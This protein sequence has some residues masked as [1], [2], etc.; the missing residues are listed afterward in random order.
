LAPIIRSVLLSIDEPAG[1]V[2]NTSATTATNKIG[3]SQVGTKLLGR[4]PKIEDA[5]LLVGQ[6][7]TIGDENTVNSDTLTRVWQV[8]GVVVDSGIVRVLETVKVPVNLKSISMYIRLCESISYVR[9][10]HDGCLLG[11]CNCNHLQVPLAAYGQYDPPRA[12]MLDLLRSQSV[13]HVADDLAGKT[14]GTV[15]VND[16]EGDGVGGVSSHGPVTPIPAVYVNVRLTLFASIV[17]NQPL[18]P[19]WRVSRPPFSLGVTW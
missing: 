1:V 10:Q 3:R 15:W 16:G 14:L 5:T 9:T 4:G 17:T 11:S 18:G 12:L 6:N 2:T 13:C 7:G 19:P 8:H